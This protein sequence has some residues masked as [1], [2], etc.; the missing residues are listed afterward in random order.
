MNSRATVIPLSFSLLTELNEDIRQWSEREDNDEHEDDDEGQEN[1]KM[2]GE[3][4][5]RLAQ[6]FT[7]EDLHHMWP[8][9]P[10]IHSHLQL[11]A[12]RPR[13]AALIVLTKMV[14]AIDTTYAGAASTYPCDPRHSLHPR[15]SPA[16]RPRRPALP[17]SVDSF[18]YSPSLPTDVSR[19]LCYSALIDLLRAD[20]HHRP[21]S[22]APVLASSN[23]G[24]EVES[25]VIT[26]YGGTVLQRLGVLIDH[27]HPSQ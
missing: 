11:T 25:S 10:A 13:H 26:E 24:R 8:F 12:W 18:S 27:P 2:G 6:A 3:S 7:G 9:L 17:R 5:G 19:G 16:H 22:P 14:E 4:A 20:A 21:P 1:Y 23:S 15:P